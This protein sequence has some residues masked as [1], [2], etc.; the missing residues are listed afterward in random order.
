[1]IRAGLRVSAVELKSVHGVMP[2]GSF[3]ADLLDSYRLIN[4]YGLLGV[5]VELLLSMP[6]GPAQD[7]MS[8]RWADNLVI[9]VAAG[10][11]N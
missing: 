4:L 7:P 8:R 9:R 6:S 1:M 5:P 3:P 11:H 2:R 10:H